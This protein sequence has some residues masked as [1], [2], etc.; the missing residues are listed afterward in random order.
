MEQEILEQY[1]KERNAK[2]LQNKADASFYGS[3]VRETRLLTESKEFSE[4]R[5]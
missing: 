1:H 2:D 4:C 3:S 5:H